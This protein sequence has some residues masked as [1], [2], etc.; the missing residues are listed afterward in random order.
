MQWI[1]NPLPVEYRGAAAELLRRVRPQDAEQALGS[2]KAILWQGQTRANVY[3]LMRVE[4]GC[5]D[6]YCMT[7]VGHISDRVMHLDFVLEAGSAVHFTDVSHEFWGMKTD[8][9]LI[10]ETGNHAGLVAVLGPQ[11]WVLTAC[12]NCTSSRAQRPLPEPRPSP[13]PKFDTFEHFRRA[14]KEKGFSQ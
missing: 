3:I 6:Y 2:V 10:F 14:L 1:E 12:A 13:V 7:L 9:P 11:G 5:R 8:P 4:A